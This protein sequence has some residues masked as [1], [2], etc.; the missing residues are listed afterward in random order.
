[1][2]TKD[3]PKLNEVFK[4][5]ESATDAP[6]VA[7]TLRQAGLGVRPCGLN[8]DWSSQAWYLGNGQPNVDPNGLYLVDVE[9]DGPETFQVMRYNPEADDES[10][11]R[12]AVG[13]D[14]PVTLEQAVKIAK[15]TLG[16]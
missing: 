12:E 10:G 11:D 16:K 5:E 1:M 6:A 2:N 8:A 15:E 13:P 9:E 14:E 7:Q 3:I 4:V